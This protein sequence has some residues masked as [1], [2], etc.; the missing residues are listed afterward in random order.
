M[1]RCKWSIHKERE[2]NMYGLQSSDESIATVVD[3]VVHGLAGD[4]QP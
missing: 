2:N 3:G 4:S 1:S